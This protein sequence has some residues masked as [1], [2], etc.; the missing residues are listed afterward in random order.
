MTLVGHF[1]HS[2]NTFSPFS[3]GVIL[4]QAWRSLFLGFFDGGISW[5]RTITSTTS[6]PFLAAVVEAV[7]EKEVTE[8]G[9]MT[10]HSWVSSISSFSGLVAAKA[11]VLP[12]LDGVL[13]EEAAGSFPTSD[14][15][16]IQV[17]RIIAK[18]KPIKEHPWLERDNPSIQTS[19]PLSAQSF[20]HK[21]LCIGREQFMQR[22]FTWVIG[23]D[24]N[25]QRCCA[26]H[27]WKIILDFENGWSR[28]GWSRLVLI[29][30]MYK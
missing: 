15:V 12:T 20:P 16:L 2:T 18:V 23:V 21:A 22:W 8:D 7:V 26:A 29:C 30:T 19:A 28:K 24:D 9:L 27:W 5:S 1:W 10:W 6:P 3:I 25:A 4:K 13:G 17:A 14:N 11:I